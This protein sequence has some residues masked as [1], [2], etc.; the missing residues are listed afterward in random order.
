MKKFCH[1]A[2][3]CRPRIT[4]TTRGKSSSS[5]Q[6]AV[7]RGG[8]PSPCL[9]RT[10]ADF[11]PPRGQRPSLCQPGSAAGAGGLVPTE[12]AVAPRRT[13]G[14]QKEMPTRVLQAAR[15]GFPEAPCTRTP[16]HIQ[17]GVSS[18]KH[19]CCPARVTHRC[20]PLG[21]SDEHFSLDRSFLTSVPATPLCPCGCR[22]CQSYDLEK[23]IR[24][25]HPPTKNCRW[26][27]THRA[28]NETQ[29]F[30]PG[31]QGPVGVGS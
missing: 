26:L 25:C 19:I 17:P 3:P 14:E 4:K 27:G 9:A 12:N 5:V 15:R 6:K 18:P 11:T 29:I 20:H 22:V 21:P 13:P 31:L 2:G 1:W 30:Y 24:L 10:P 23:E 16:A 7:L 8:C 28:W